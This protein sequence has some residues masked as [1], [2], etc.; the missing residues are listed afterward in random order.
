MEATTRRRE[1]KRDSERDVVAFYSHDGDTTWRLG[2][3]RV[4]LSSE[5]LSDPSVA[6]GPD[7]SFYLV[8]IRFIPNNGQ[9]L[10]TEGAGRLEFLDSADGGMTWKE[11]AIVT[12]FVDRP[13]LAVSGKSGGGRG[14][15]Y[16]HGNIDEP[17]SVELRRWC[18]NP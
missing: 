16:C 14:R 5:C 12:Q 10:G 15:L 2:C 1:S 4:A 8:Y 7:G 17:H 6:C 11:Q 9:P 13:L 3:E 18:F